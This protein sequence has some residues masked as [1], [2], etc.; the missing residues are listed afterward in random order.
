[1]TKPIEIV[2][3]GGVAGGMSAATRA[4]RCNEQ[5]HITVLEKTGH[6]SFANCGL[7]YFLDG[8]I[9]TQE[10][11]L[12]TNPKAVASRYRIDARV[13]HEVTA[14]NRQAHTVEARNLLTGQ[15][16]TIPYDKLILAPG[17]SPIVPAIK[18]AAAKNVFLVRNIEDIVRAKAYLDTAHP[19][20]AVIIGAGYIGLEMADVLR[21]IGMQVAIVEKA[22]QPMPL[23]DREL[24]EPI[25]AELR[26]Q[27]VDLTVGDGLSELRADAAGLV[28]QVVTES[29]KILSADMVVMSIGVR[30]NVALAQ[31]A[32]VEL[33]STGA[34]RVDEYQ[35]TSDPDIYA[36]GDA[37]EVIHAVTNKPV[38]IP[39][40][41]SANRAGRNAGEHAASGQSAAAGAVLG[42]SIVQV[43][44]L[45]AGLTGL[46][47][48]AAKAAGFDADSVLVLPS[49]HAGYYPD[50]RQMRMKLVY[51]KLT[52]RV[53]GAQ[54]VG[55]AGIDKRLDVIATTIHF[56]GTIDDLAQLDLAYSPQYGSAKDAIHYAA[57]VAQNQRSGMTPSINPAADLKDFFLI[58]V[59]TAAEH[60][61]G[62]LVNS[63]NIPLDDLRERMD[64]I[65]RN[66]R[67]AVTCQVGLRGHVATRLLRQHGLDVVN[68]KG[69][70]TIAS[71]M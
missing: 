24:V 28:T 30:P 18:N 66:R 50:A 15:L 22:P 38:R 5:A 23:M 29:G 64:E 26:E 35:R 58:D 25:A 61:K 34:I 20:S 59:R 44:G 43:F 31:A 12:L 9:A 45:A 32:G 10:K 4:R 37:A 71:T 19:K 69:G 48:S 68:L 47:E 14:I 33:G 1:M 52:G 2:I 70:Y 49:H 21:N 11:L 39:L 60:S 57:F 62:S 53:L 17:A 6:I 41:G 13:D 54:A 55:K 42:T 40:A 8:R 7:P 63:I 51:D 3:I 36:V 27:G 67:I 56:R 65:P 46:S 16:S